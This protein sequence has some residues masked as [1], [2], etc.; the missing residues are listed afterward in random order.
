VISM[1]LAQEP[2]PRG[3]TKAEDFPTGPDADRTAV[4]VAYTMLGAA[5]NG[6]APLALPDLRAARA[7]VAVDHRTKAS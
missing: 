7:D 1:T 4:L 6:F 3:W 2:E 5:I